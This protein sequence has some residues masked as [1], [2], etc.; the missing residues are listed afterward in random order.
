[1]SETTPQQTPE[2]GANP[3]VA[4]VLSGCGVYDGAELHESVLTLLA[5]SRQG[6]T[7]Q[8][9]APDRP[10]HHVI[11]HLTGE[12]QTDA[13]RNVLVEAA[14]IARGQIRPL[15]DYRASDFD[16]VMF[17]GGFGAAKNL[18]SFAFDGADCT[19]DPDVERTIR[20][21]HAAG[22]PIGALCIS[23][24]LLAKVLGAGVVLTIGSDSA[25]AGAIAAMGGQHRI[26]GH[27][28]VVIDATNRIVTTPCYML[29]A[30]IAQIDDGAQ[31]I[32]RAVLEMIRR[33]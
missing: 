1:M 33:P 11:N 16:A 21:T 23:P 27:G 26:T 30:T 19:V 4:V 9:F 10:Q 7:V 13:P 25:A 14:R 5:L 31:A 12:E 8:C 18:S 24:V 17:P 15:S 28:D 22:K 29:D 20:E 32:T 3:T 2:H 6:A